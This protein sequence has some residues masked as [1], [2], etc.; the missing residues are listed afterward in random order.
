[1]ATMTPQQRAALQ[2]MMAQARR[3][4][5]VNKPSDMEIFNRLWEMTSKAKMHKARHD[6]NK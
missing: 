5:G 6:P 4:A 3:A 2:D 1:M